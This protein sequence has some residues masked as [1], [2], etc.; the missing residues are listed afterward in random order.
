MTIR[1]ARSE[2]AKQAARLLY[3]A[4]HDVAHQLTGEE[5]EQDAVRVLEQYFA[6]ETG[7]LSHKQA[8]VKEVDGEVAGVVIV[9]G[10]DE[11]AELDQP[12]LERLRAM[13]NDPGLKLDKESDEDEYYIDTLSVSPKF[14]GQG[15]GTKLIQAAEVRAKERGYKKNAMAVVTDNSRAYSLYLHLGYEVDKEIMINGHVYYHMVKHL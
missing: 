12:I 7:R 9:Y 1:A 4:L 14:S 13:K 15:I 2:D 11:V 8:I 6:V 3:D 5:S 10:G